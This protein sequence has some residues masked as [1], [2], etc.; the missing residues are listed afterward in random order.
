MTSRHR[1]NAAEEEEPPLHRVHL[2]VMEVHSCHEKGNE[3]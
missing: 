3:V 1:W 2:K